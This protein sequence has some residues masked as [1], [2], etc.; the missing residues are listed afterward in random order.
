MAELPPGL[1]RIPLF[2]GVTEAHLA[3]LVAAFRRRS[4]AEG[5]KLFSAGQVPERFHLL[6]G[7]EIQLGDGTDRIRLTPPAPVGELASLVG[8]PRSMTAVAGPGCV[9]LELEVKALMQFFEE[10][11]DIGFPVHHNLLRLVADK[12]RRDDRRIEEMRHN[13]VTTQKAMKR[14]REALL[15]SDDTPLHASLYEELDSLIE[16]NKKAHYLVE[17]TRAMPASIRTDAGKLVDVVAL[18]NEWLH[19]APQGAPP[20]PGSEWSAVLVIGGDELVVSGTVERVADDRVVIYLDPLI[21]E[22]EGKL[23]VHLTRLQMLDIVV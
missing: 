6:V 3:E 22:L 13:I 2:E 21:D 18:S 9:V 4:V 16:Q 14:M 7:G 11:G 23:E 17:P 10:H 1:A 8:L 5:E 19:V 12:L 15:E 20:E